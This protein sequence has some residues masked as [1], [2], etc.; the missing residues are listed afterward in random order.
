MDVFSGL[1]PVFLVL[2]LGILAR[3]LRLLDEASAQGL[4]RVVANIA[5]P[6][7]L[8]LKIGTSSLAASFSGPVVGVSTGLIVVT[9]I[10][11]LAVARLWGLPG[12]QAGVLSQAMMRGNLVYLAF[13]VILAAGGDG[14]L[15]QAAVTAAVLIPVMNLLAV[16]VLE[17]GRGESAFDLTLARRVVLNPLVLGALAGMALAAVRW[18]PWPWLEG[19][20]STVADFALPGALLALGAQ[21]RLG[22]WARVWKPT[23]AVTVVKLVLQPAAAWWLLRALGVHGQGLLV[24]TLLLAAPTAVA[25]YPVA[26]ELG[27]DRALAGASVLV[28]TV[29]A[30]ATMVVWT[31]VLKG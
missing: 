1:I 28:T 22:H 10:A 21:L 15:R 25:S 11:G 19:T 14:A 27:G 7:L 17:V 24:A 3:A 31:L 13:P 20:L 23:A 2:A 8:V 6:A 5:L 18:Q 16:V 9:A 4:N 26:V 12:P 30:F 29:A